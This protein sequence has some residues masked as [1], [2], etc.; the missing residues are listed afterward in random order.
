MS[1]WDLKFWLKKKVIPLLWTDDILKS[2]N[3]VYLWDTT[4]DSASF[5]LMW[6]YGR[7]QNCVTCFI[8]SYVGLWADTER[9][10]LLKYYLSSTSIL[11]HQNIGYDSSPTTSIFSQ[12]TQL[13]ISIPCRLVDVTQ[14]PHQATSSESHN[15]WLNAQ[16]I[17]TFS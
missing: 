13:L 6:G 7:I 8:L 4:F 10:Q 3:D 11:L 9:C 17:A 2:Q 16:N 5:C 12:C 15:F 14:L 1:S